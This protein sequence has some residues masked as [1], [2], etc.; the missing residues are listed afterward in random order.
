MSGLSD[1]PE[2][3]WTRV[4]LPGWIGDDRSIHAIRKWWR[5]WQIPCPVSYKRHECSTRL[6]PFVWLKIQ[7]L[8]TPSKY[9][10]VCAVVFWYFRVLYAGLG[11]HTALWFAQ[12]LTNASLSTALNAK[13]GT[14][15]LSVAKILL[16]RAS[17]LLIL[18]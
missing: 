14:L 13:H 16:K 17:S 8:Q 7:L 6:L 2:R 15:H 1:C 4:K 3:T 11:M 9:A 5:L 12:Q 10:K 18:L